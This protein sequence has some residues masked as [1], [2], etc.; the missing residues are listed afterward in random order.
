MTTETIRREIKRKKSEE[1]WSK[2]P[3]DESKVKFHKFFIILSKSHWMREHNE[4]FSRKLMRDTSSARLRDE[5][6]ATGTG[7][8]MFEFNENTKY[9]CYGYDHAAEIETNKKNEL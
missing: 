6:A 9:V 4:A 2:H 8:K 5:R 1:Q 7:E 3:W